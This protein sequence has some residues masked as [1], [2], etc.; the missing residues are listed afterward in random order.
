MLKSRELFNMMATELGIFQ[1]YKV[2]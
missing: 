2:M 1:R